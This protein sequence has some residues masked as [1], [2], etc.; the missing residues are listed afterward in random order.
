[1]LKLLKILMRAGQPTVKYPFAPL[2]VS[3]GFRGKPKLEPHQCM[4]CAACASA[5]PTNALTMET[6][7]TTQTRIWQLYLGRC[8]FCGRCEEVCPTRAIQLTAEYELTVLHKSDLYTRATF[9]LLSCT[10][11]QRPF[12]TI[13]SVALAAALQ[14][15]QQNTPHL[16]ETLQQ[17]ASRCPECRRQAALHPGDHEDMSFTFKEQ[18]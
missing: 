10:Q 15:Q 6:D 7:M 14:A 8:I 16:L 17:Q 11:C 18:P 13:K 12:T 9:R 4:A 3:P 1:M 2:T 5:C